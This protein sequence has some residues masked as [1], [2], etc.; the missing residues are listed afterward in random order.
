[1]L[2]A[3]E[4]LVHSAR[5]DHPPAHAG[6]IDTTI[7]R[8][9]PVCTVVATSAPSLVRDSDS[10]PC[11]FAFSG[12]SSSERA[13]AALNPGISSMAASPRGALHAPLESASVA[14]R[15]IP[16]ARPPAA[17]GIAPQSAERAR[18]HTLAAIWLWS[19]ERLFLT[20]EWSRSQEVPHARRYVGQAGGQL[21]RRA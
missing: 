2:R 7:T 13:G 20:L 9:G 1:M 19:A 10:V 3:V 15:A 16:C 17:L 18:G 14:R 8:C 4:A 21:A 5:R 12:T 11:P 6:R